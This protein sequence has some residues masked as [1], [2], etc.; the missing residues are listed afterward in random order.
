[1]ISGKAGICE[2]RVAVV[3]RKPLVHAGEQGLPLDAA[4]SLEQCAE[5]EACLRKPS[6]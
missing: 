5:E 2:E 3:A 6:S 4:E 1:L